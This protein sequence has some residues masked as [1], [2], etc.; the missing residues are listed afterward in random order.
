MLALI[1]PVFHF[2]LVIAITCLFYA[3][4]LK[5]YIVIL[6][7]SFSL[8]RASDKTV[9]LETASPNEEKYPHSK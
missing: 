6:R 9:F 1:N 8:P 4:L 3:A 5:K 7:K 2:P